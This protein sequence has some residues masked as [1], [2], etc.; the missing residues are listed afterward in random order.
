MTTA[1][2]EAFRRQ[3]AAQADRAAD[4]LTGRW[5]RLETYNEDDVSRLAEEGQLVVTAAKAAAVA[6]AAAYY[7]S[8]LKIPPRGVSPSDIDT[9]FDWNEP[10]TAVWHALSE[11]RPY[12]EA[13]AAGRSAL[14]AVVR[15]FTTSTTRRTGDVVAGRSGIAVQWVRVAEPGCCDWCTARG[16]GIYPTAAAGDYGHGRC[17]CDMV[18]ETLVNPDHQAETPA[19]RMARANRE[20]QARVRKQLRTAHQRQARAKAEQATE[21]D[22]ARLERLSTREQEWETE[23]ERLTEQLAR[24]RT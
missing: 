7:T 23:A 3:T 6:A 8:E 10:F 12:G 1:L 22:P 20:N 2:L 16:G 18:P 17:R 9:A 21:T 13:V 4:L 5:D 14:E 11:S 19:E 15:D 24:L